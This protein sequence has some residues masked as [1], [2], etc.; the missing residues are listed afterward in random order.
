[1]VARN[2][3]HDRALAAG[4]G[5]AERLLDEFRDALRLRYSDAALAD[6][7]EKRLLVDLLEGVPAEM[8]RGGKAGNRHDRRIGELRMREAGRSEEH[9]SELQ[10]LMRIT[11][12]DF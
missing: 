12:A 8:L 3:E 9:T 10:S 1:M 5:E 11:Y 6:R 7:G 4:H 2:V